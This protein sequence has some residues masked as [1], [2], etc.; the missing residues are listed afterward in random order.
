M[1]VNCGRWVAVHC[2]YLLRSRGQNLPGAHRKLDRQTLLSQPLTSTEPANLCISLRS[3]I[4]AH[5]SACGA[6]SVRQL[7]LR[8]VRLDRL[9]DSTSRMQ[10]SHRATQP[11][12]LLGISKKRSA[13]L[14]RKQVLLQSR[15]MHLDSRLGSSWGGAARMAC[16]Q[17]SAAEH[18]VPCLVSVS[19]G[20]C[21]FPA[22]THYSSCRSVLPWRTLESE[23]SLNSP[24]VII[25]CTC[26]IMQAPS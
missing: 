13:M 26:C 15:G 11:Q 12:T 9:R 22:C 3:D 18:W 19:V 2:P 16:S 4:P 5:S 6:A 21:D 20:Q 1:E 25:C 10:P 8:Q 7:I 24:D 23:K 14:W 17:A